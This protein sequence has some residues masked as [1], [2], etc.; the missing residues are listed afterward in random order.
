MSSEKK[1]YLIQI[2]ENTQRQ[3]YSNTP[4]EHGVEMIRPCAPDETVSIVNGKIVYTKRPA[5][6]RSYDQKIAAVISYPDF[7]LLAVDAMDNVPG[8]WD[9]IEVLKK[10]I[11]AIEREGNGA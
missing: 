6:A 1:L 7:L 8:T 9:K 3:V 5:T 10:Q 4:I 11:R 2:D